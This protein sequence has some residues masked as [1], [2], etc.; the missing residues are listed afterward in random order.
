MSSEPASIPA[1]PVKA[2]SNRNFGLIFAAIF[3]F[4]GLLPLPFGGDP[5]MWALYIALAFF[6]VAVVLPVLLTP[7]NKA[8]VKFGLLMH[9]IVNP[10]LMGLVFFL[11]IMPT[12][13]ILR[14]LGKDPMR[15]KKDPQADSYWITRQQ[16]VDKDF[17]DN[18]F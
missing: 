11:T 12:G 16:T 10:I 1:E 17:F 4:I 14:L 18:Q 7:L 6:A 15:R 3:A 13:L 2:L 5:R 8:W 9:K